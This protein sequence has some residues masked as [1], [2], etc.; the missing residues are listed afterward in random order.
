MTARVMTPDP[1]AEAPSVTWRS[2]GLLLALWAALGAALLGVSLVVSP[3]SRGG[4]AFPIQLF[5]VPGLLLQ[6]L[7]STALFALYRVTGA[8]VSRAG[9]HLMHVLA[10]VGYV[11]L[12]M[13]EGQSALYRFHDAERRRELCEDV[14]VQRWR[15]ARLPDSGARVLEVTVSSRGGGPLR[16]D[17]PMVD[18]FDEGPGLVD[19]G[20]RRP[21]CEPRTAELP[22]GQ[23]VTLKY[24]LRELPERSRALQ[25]TLCRLPDTEDCAWYVHGDGASSARRSAVTCALPP[26]SGGWP[27]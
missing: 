23:E 7:L 11:P 15:L 20:C 3:L 2:H 10:L 14:T 24:E 19:V 27:P 13:V 26:P 16:L 25:F 4:H 6:P 21:D 18:A 9:L 8:R 12:A 5:I 22:A 1:A 17:Y